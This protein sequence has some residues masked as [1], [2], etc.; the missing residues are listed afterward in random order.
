MKRPAPARRSLLHQLFFPDSVACRLYLLVVVLETIFDLA[1]EVVLLGRV[2]D[3]I[4]S[5]SNVSESER[6]TLARNRIPVYLGVFGM[7]HVFQFLLALDAVY[8][9]NVLQFVFLAIFNALFFAYAVIQISEVQ[10][11]LGSSSKGFVSSEGLTIAIPIV[12]SI[13]EV[14]YITL[15]YRIWRDF[16]WQVFKLLGAD[17]RIRRI[18][19]QFQILQ[20]LMRFD[21]FF[22]MGFSIQLVALVL[23]KGDFEFYLTIAALPLS[24]LLIIEGHLAARHESGWMMGIFG[25]GMMAGMVYFVYKLFRIWSQRHTDTFKDVY[26]SLTVFDSVS[27][28]LLIVTAIWSTLVYRNFGSGLKHQLNKR[29]PRENDEV[30]LGS[31]GGGFKTGNPNRMSIE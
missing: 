29:S 4:D 14:A 24:I 18:Y 10:T 1:I 13:A 22:W 26:K 9:K 23:Q 6:P 7:A 20:C 8:Y 2:N 27:V 16:G 19:A 5:N 30:E 21:L 11:L 3:A 31:K 17:R 25:F 15:A 28:S 12:I